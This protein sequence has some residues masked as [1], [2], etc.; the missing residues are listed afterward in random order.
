MKIHLSPRFKRSYK[1]LF[2]NIQGRNLPHTFMTR[3]VQHEAKIPMELKVGG[4]SKWICMR[5]LSKHKPFCDGAHKQ[6]AGEEEGKLY[7]YENGERIEVKDF[8]S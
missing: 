8:P 3:L 4:E 7:R 6:T 5:G 1:K 2:P